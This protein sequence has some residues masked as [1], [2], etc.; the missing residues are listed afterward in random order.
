MHL[1]SL[2]VSPYAARVRIA[3]RA[4]AL[5]IAAVAPPAGW[6]D[7]PAFRALSPTGRIPVLVLDDG[8]VIGE[9]AVILDFLDERFAGAPRLLPEDAYERAQVRQLSRIADLYLMPPMIALAR[10]P[11][12]V[13]GPVADLAQAL[14]LLDRLVGSGGPAAG[15]PLSQ[16]DCALAPVLFAVGVT[17][18]RLG[19]DLLDGAPRVARY[20]ASLGEN[21]HVA[22]VVAEMEQ[23]LRAMQAGTAG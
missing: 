4:K 23:G 12:D 11:G 21:P 5:D 18:R 15:R 9:S 16:A 6:R 20:A 22:P 19:R 7:D 17:G 2:P 8:R 10:A 13:H 14:T 3:I 1:I